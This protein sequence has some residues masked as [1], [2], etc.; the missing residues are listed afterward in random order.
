MV[1]RIAILSLNL[2]GYGTERTMFNLALG[3]AERGIAVDIVLVNAE[4]PLLAQIPAGIRVIPLKRQRVLARLPLV[5]NVPALVQY[6]RHERPAALLSAFEQTNIVALWAR[7]IARVPTRVV[8]SA[9]FPFS[10]HFLMNSPHLKERLLLRHLVR[11]FYPWADAIVAV[12]QGAANDLATVTGLPVKR[13]QVVY[14]PVPLDLNAKAAQPLDHPWFAPGEPPVILAV[15]RLTRQKDFP[16]LIRAFSLVR[17]RH[18]ARLLILG[19]GEEQ[20]ALEMLARELGLADEVSLGGFTEHPYPY[21]ARAT[22]FALSSAWEALPVVLLEAL[23]LG[24]P[25]VATDCDSG[26]YEILEG[27]RWGTLVPVAD[28]GAL[29]EAI[30]AVLGRARPTA[31]PEEAWGRFHLERIVDQYLGI[32]CGDG[33]TRVSAATTGALPKVREV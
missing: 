17:Q 3:F 13:I 25:I 18:A 23:T 15:G 27:G 1:T 16:T 7:R 11:R 26:P 4:G 8:I 2:N 28:P 19:N 20:A 10:R 31:P 29:A 5:R 32:L 12:S 24:T 9:H 6:L 21:M 33:G 30:G 14:N 22:V